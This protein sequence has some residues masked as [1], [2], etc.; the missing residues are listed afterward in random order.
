MVPGARRAGLVGRL[1]DRWKVRVSAPAEDGRANRAVCELL[2]DS[3]GIA[4]AHVRVVAGAASRDKLVE[5]SGIAA[6]R[7]EAVMRAAARG[8]P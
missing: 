8:R 3:L 5:V 7:V 1:G 2:A 6:D 4:P